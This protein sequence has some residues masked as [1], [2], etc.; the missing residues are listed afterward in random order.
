MRH[1]SW[2]FV[3]LALLTACGEKSTEE[4]V[5]TTE[6]TKQ[7]AV[8]PNDPFGALSLSDTTV[9]KAING[10]Y[11]GDF[12]DSFIHLHIEFIN[13]H[14]V[15]G[16]NIFKGLQRNLSGKVT[17]HPDSWEL[18]LAEAGDRPDD[19]VFTV[20]VSRN[21]YS[22]KGSWKANNPKIPE[23]SFQLEKIVREEE[24]NDTE[25][26]K[27][28]QNNF[29]GYFSPVFSNGYECYFKENGSVVL[30]YAPTDDEGNHQEQQVEARGSWRFI[31]KKEPVLEV[32][33]QKNTLLKKTKH[34][35]K[36]EYEEGYP[37]IRLEEIQ[38]SP[39]YF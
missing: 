28:T 11:T 3:G 2:I 20:F 15:V 35:L 8:F 21:D 34:K 33:W 9:R 16:Y 18:T 5:S 27:I 26:I 1:F 23:K 24:E 6:E 25:E 37:F 4:T 7:D 12:G 38:L 14:R 17:E 36:V 13:E 29:T 30:M 31:S 10:M 32:V 39:Q 19:G 22:L